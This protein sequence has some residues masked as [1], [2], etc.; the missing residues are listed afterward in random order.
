MEG[1]KRIVVAVPVALHTRLTKH[2]RKSETSLQAVAAAALAAY[3][4]AQRQPKEKA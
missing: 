1:Y 3:D 2:A 4:K